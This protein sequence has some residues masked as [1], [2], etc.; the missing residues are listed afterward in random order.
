MTLIDQ[1]SAIVG[2]AYVLTGDAIGKYAEDWFGQYPSKPLAVVRPATTQEV[3]DV[4]KLANAERVSIVPLSGNTGLVGGGQA[5]GALILSLDR[6][7]AIREVRSDARVA[8]VE[9]G[10]ILSAMHDAA[11]EHDLI[12]PLMFGAR[13]SAMIGG[14]LSTNAGG[15]NV[16]RYGNT[17]DLVLGVEVV[18]PTGEIM[19][20]MSELHKDNSGYNL[21]HLLIGA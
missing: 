21:K 18:L 15:S 10:V 12:F 16:L 8:I 20:I 9:A 11:D 5:N 6:M 14:V 4:V 1:L 17:R 7:N 2:E 13:G 19:D 3:S